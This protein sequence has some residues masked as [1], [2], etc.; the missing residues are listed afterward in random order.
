MEIGR[1]HFVPILHRSVWV[2][3][4]LWASQSSNT[5]ALLAI[6]PSALLRRL[7]PLTPRAKHL[8]IPPPDTGSRRRVEELSRLVWQPPPLAARDRSSAEKSEARQPTSATAGHTTLEAPSKSHPPRASSV[9][10]CA[11]SDFS[12]PSPH[13]LPVLDS[14]R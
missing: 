7:L 11:I 10:S 4:L 14:I 8:T 13:S 9:R 12:C 2:E 1:T 6:L 3:P 5:R